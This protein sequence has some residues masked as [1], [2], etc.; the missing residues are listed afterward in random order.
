MTWT[1]SGDPSTSTKDQVRF[2]IGDTQSSDPILQDAEI[3]WLL[4]EN[5]TPFYAA[6]E[7]ANGIAAYYAR[8]ADKAVGDLKI[9]AS[10]QHKQYLDLAVRLRR[11][12][13]TETVTPYAGGISVSDK[14]VQQDNSDSTV[15]FFNRDL[16]EIPG[17]D[18]PVQAS[19]EPILGSEP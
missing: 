9:S 14:Q 4:T 19:V 5:A 17:A 11:R 8:K 12:A 13:L 2:L 16:F 15:P 3:N 1:Y 7:A 10:Q 6:V 18:L